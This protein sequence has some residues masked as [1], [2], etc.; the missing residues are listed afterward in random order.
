[1]VDSRKLA[2]RNTRFVP[3]MFAYRSEPVGVSSPISSVSVL[4]S[5]PNVTLKSGSVRPKSDKS[6]ASVSTTRLISSEARL[7]AIAD[8]AFPSALAENG[9][10]TDHVLVSVVAIGVMYCQ[11]LAVRSTPTNF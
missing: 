2:I 8:A 6:V 11:S 10:V 9:A 7:L 5:E 4:F 1:M 3:P